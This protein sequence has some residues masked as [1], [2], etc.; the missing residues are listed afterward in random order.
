MQKPMTEGERA[1]EIC[2]SYRFAGSMWYGKSMDQLSEQE[3]ID[4]LRYIAETTGTLYVR[5]IDEIGN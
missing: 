2:E 1:R 3:C 4:M 5:W